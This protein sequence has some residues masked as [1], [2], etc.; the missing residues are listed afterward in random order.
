MSSFFKRLSYS[1]GNEDWETEHKALRIKSGDRVLCITASGD[2]PLHLLLD[3]AKEIV[4][5]DTNIIQNQLTKLKMAALKELE[6]KEYLAFLGA[7]GHV[8]RKKC[9]NKILKSLDASSAQFWKQREKIVAKGILYQGAIER[10]TKTT[11]SLVKVIRGK[12]IKKLFEFD[13]LHHQQKFIKEEWD[14]QSWRKVVEFALS[15]FVT[16]LFVKDPGLYSNIDPKIHVGSYMYDKMIGCMNRFLA[17]EN[18]L[19]S[20]I[21]QGHVGEAAFPPYLQEHYSREIKKK[22]NRITLETEDVISYLERAKENSFDCFSLSDVASYIDKESF[23]RMIHAVYRAAKPG[24]RFSIRQFLSDQKIPENFSPFF[25]RDHA[26][27]EDLQ[28]H[29]RCFVYRFMVGT[30]NKGA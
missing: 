27:E 13:D 26:L 24:A 5:V 21:F 17:K 29:D 30:I 14:T 10:W 28:K 18:S 6:F 4:S 7:A 3:D 19:I 25:Q 22:L 15:P 11:S 2:R 9:L 8:D 23:L 20:L 12:K 16:K 1:F